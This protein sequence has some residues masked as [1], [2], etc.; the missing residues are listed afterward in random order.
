MSRFFI[1]FLAEFESYNRSRESYNRL[2]F[3]IFGNVQGDFE[4][5]ERLNLIISVS[6]VSG[7]HYNYED[8]LDVWRHF[9]F[10]K[11]IFKSILF[12]IIEVS[13]TKIVLRI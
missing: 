10:C 2:L 1:N 11:T 7:I 5:Y 6:L 9:S 3:K 8:I 13:A 12:Q 4:S